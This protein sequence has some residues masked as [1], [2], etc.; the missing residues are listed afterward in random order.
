MQVANECGRERVL[1]FVRGKMLDAAQAWRITV[2][3]GTPAEEWRAAAVA[4]LEAEGFRAVGGR[5]QQAV[6]QLAQV[7]AGRCRKHCS[8][9][10][11]VHVGR[12]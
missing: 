12:H 11:I 8:T 9:I 7:G 5:A 1:R 6:N 4:M 10:T 2:P 3:A